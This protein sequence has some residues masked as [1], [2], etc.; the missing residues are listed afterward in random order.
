MENKADYSSIIIK[1]DRQFDVIIIDG[2][3]RYA[4]VRNAIRC[5]KEG[6]MIILDNSDWYP[7]VSSFLRD[8]NLIEV[9][10]SGFGPVNNYTWTTSLYLTRDFRFR[11]LNPIQPVPPIGSI[12]I[13]AEDDN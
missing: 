5:L 7:N 10:F 4:C 6:G 13:H 12:E 8:N 2:Q 9:D 1:L 11:S 3:F